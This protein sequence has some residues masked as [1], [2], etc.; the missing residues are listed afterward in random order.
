MASARQ[1][2]ATKLA[3]TDP[4]RLPDGFKAIRPILDGS[5]GKM[6]NVMGVVV[7]AMAPIATGGKGE[8]FSSSYSKSTCKL[9]DTTVDGLNEVDSLDFCLF[10]PNKDDHPEFKCGDVVILRSVKTQSHRGG[11]ISVLSNY[12]TKICVFDSAKIRGDPQNPFAALRPVVTE[13]QWSPSPPEC[14]HAA[15]LLQNVNQHRIPTVEEF[16]TMVAQSATSLDKFRVLQNVEPGR[17]YDLIVKVARKP[18]DWGDKVTLWVTDYTE[19]PAFYRFPE[20]SSNGLA[21][22]QGNPD[23]DPYGY[24]SKFINTD[25]ITT[26]S[27]AMPGQRSLQVTCFEPHASAIREENIDKNAWVS[28]KNVQIKY[29]NNQANLEG[30]LREDRAR[31][32]KIGISQI[33]LDELRRKELNP[34]TDQRLRDALR[35]NRDYEKQRKESD[36]LIAQAAQAGQKRKASPATGNG[37]TAENAKA[38]RR[39]RRMKKQ[40][41]EVAA[42]APANGGDERRVQPIHQAAGRTLEVKKEEPSLP[43]LDLNTLLKCEHSS[44]PPSTVASILK[45]HIIR[46]D[47]DDEMVDLTLPFVCRNHRL[48]VRVVDYYPHDMRKFARPKKLAQFDM[49]SDNEESDEGDSDTDMDFGAHDA[50]YEWEW[51]FLLLLEDASM[52]AAGGSRE[53]VWVF[54]DNKAAQ[55]LINLDASNLYREADDLKA[56]Q[57]AMAVLWGNLP[58]TKEPALAAQRARPRTLADA[59]PPDSSDA[60]NQGGSPVQLDNKPCNCCVKQYGVKL[61]DDD[62]DK[63]NAGDGFRWERMFGL[64]GTRLTLPV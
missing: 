5:F 59:P 15:W 11:P 60:D 21:D 19:N 4:S 27:D 39:K 24:C 38:R 43:T 40:E 10:R 32:S 42:Q 26:A 25:N 54:V 17:F 23:G 20:R 47:V 28:M 55:C 48:D 45:R 33:D 35:R 14:A 58:Q 9:I 56:L 16:Q 12:N 44:E 50:P 57:E 22:T 29:G 61:R 8:M 1:P 34:T 36:D 53:R 6:A 2:S 7:D 46:T 63:C 13:D 37:A 3:S 49:L 41:A 31:G 18:Y 51:R 52:T 62:P 30:F 64:Y